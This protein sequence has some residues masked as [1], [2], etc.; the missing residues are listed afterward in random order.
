ML[1]PCLELWFSVCCKE[2][3]AGLYFNKGEQT[4]TDA[5]IEPPL[6]CC[7]NQSDRLCVS[8][9]QHEAY[10]VH[11]VQIYST[12]FHNKCCIL[13]CT[14]CLRRGAFWKHGSLHLNDFQ[15]GGHVPARGT[16]V[17]DSINRTRCPAGSALNKAGCYHLYTSMCGC[18]LS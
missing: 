3:W 11:H 7:R 1:V 6:S 16:K 14:I 10:K 8:I 17:L 2:G 13:C 5:N 9:G 12:A 15:L 4:P 18:I